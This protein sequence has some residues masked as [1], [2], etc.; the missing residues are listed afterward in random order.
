MSRAREANPTNLNVLLA[1]GVSHTN[2]GF[3]CSLC[4]DPSKQLHAHPHAC[5][6]LPPC[7]PFLS[8]HARTRCAPFCVPMPLPVCPPPCLP[9]PVPHVPPSCVPTPFVRVPHPC[10]PGRAGAGG[11]PLAPAQ[12]AQNNPRS[13]PSAAA[14]GRSHAGTDSDVRGLAHPSLVF[15][16]A[17]WMDCV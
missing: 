4:A 2:G 13:L 3:F 15:I 8:A 1:L 17:R 7:S 14:H 12:W 5:P 9:T 16:S 10:V 6:R 11:G